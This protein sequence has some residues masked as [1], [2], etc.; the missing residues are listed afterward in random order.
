MRKKLLGLTIASALLATA[1]HADTTINGFASIKAGMTTSS[2]ETLYGYGDNLDFKN[3]SLFA[4]QIKSDLG[5]KLSATGQILGR[6]SDDFDAQFEW[7]YLSY[8]LSDDLTLNAGRIGVPFFKYSDFKD[9]GYAYAWNITPQSVYSG[10]GFSN[11]EGAS[12][13]YTT[14]LG[15]FDAAMQLLYGSSSNKNPIFDQPAS[16]QYDNIISLNIELTKDWYS[17]RAAYVEGDISVSADAFNPL[18]N[19]LVGTGSPALQALAAELDFDEDKGTFYGVGVTLE[20][21]SWNIV[22]EYNDIGIERSFYSDRTNYFLSVGYRFDTVQ[23]YVVFE[24]E[25]HQSKDEIY[26]PFAGALPNQ[27]YL[28]L[29]GVVSGQRFDATTYSAGLRYDFHP[30]AAFKVQYSSQK[31]KTL[32]ETVGLISAGVD[33]VF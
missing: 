15:S 6:G 28:P 2:D 13:Y 21:G 8:Q 31:D 11:V 10:V 33:L 12:L 5:D 9:V 17:F 23:P 25:D 1:A 3:G 32:D 14:T 26:Q 16:S 20:P 22:F 30:S 4:V 19:A 27:L 7:L 18:I 29:V 24:R